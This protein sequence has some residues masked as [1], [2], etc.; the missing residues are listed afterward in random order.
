MQSDFEN[1]AVWKVVLSQSIPLMLAREFD[2][3]NFG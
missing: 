2:T 3:C 1:G